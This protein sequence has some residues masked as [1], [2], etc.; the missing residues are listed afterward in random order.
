[1]W[2]S[3]SM[4][5]PA[6]AT[7]RPRQ[8]PASRDCRSWAYVFRVDLG[9]PD[10]HAEV[11]REVAS[12]W[13][14]LGKWLSAL[15]DALDLSPGLG[16][17][18]LAHPEPGREPIDTGL[19]D[20]DLS[21][22]L[23]SAVQKAGEEVDGLYVGLIAQEASARWVG[24]AGFFVPICPVCEDRGVARATDSVLD[25]LTDCGFEEVKSSAVPEGARPQPGWFDGGRLQTI[26]RRVV[27]G[28]SEWR[29]WPPKSQSGLPGVGVLVRV[30]PVISSLAGLVLCESAAEA[31]RLPQLLAATPTAWTWTEGTLDELKRAC[32]HQ[33]RLP[34]QLEPDPESAYDWWALSVSGSPPRL[35]HGSIAAAL[36]AG[37]NQSP[38]TIWA[39]P[40]EGAALASELASLIH[41]P[42]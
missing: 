41:S 28:R 4:G 7:L 34:R 23:V 5:G 36:P 35:G 16:S 31:G 2:Q 26:C 27:P 1:M 38:P 22:V 40:G 10:S 25:I 8:C 15:G 19:V 13:A 32:H 18:R 21:H 14:A 11:H 12:A 9:R 24:L 37:D 39:L 20:A 29:P 6:A 33:P 3:S 42:A 30:R 17:I